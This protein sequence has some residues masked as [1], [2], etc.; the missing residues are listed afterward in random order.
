M[1]N[2]AIV[3]RCEKAQVGR[4]G[5]TFPED[6]S[7][8]DWKIFGLQLA[9]LQDDIHFALADWLNY[10][11]E[12]YR[13]WRECS[14]AEAERCAFA[15][16]GTSFASETL[17]VCAWVG[18]KIGPRRNDA[19]SWSHHREVAQLEPKLQMK[20]LCLAEENSWS[21][22][23]LRVQRRLQLAAVE[24]EKLKT[25]ADE[26]PTWLWE[27]KRWLRRQNFGSWGTSRRAAWRTEVRPLAEA[28][29]ASI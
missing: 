25:T 8:H 11:R 14:E 9:T 6:L 19:L 22:S 7:E 27:A 15:V 18:R 5:A 23:E 28:L 13:T 1:K 26:F 16:A 10:G 24:R 17:R 12:K 29:L 2:D 21:V 20:F 3:L 4:R